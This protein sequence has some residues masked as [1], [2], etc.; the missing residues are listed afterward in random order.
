[1]NALDFWAF[2][3]AHRELLKY[4]CG[5]SFWV[6]ETIVSSSISVIAVLLKL[7]SWAPQWYFS[8]PQP[9]KGPRCSRF[10]L[11]A[12]FFTWTNDWMLLKSSFRF[13]FPRYK[14][15][16]PHRDFLE[17]T[18]AT[19]MLWEVGY[20]ISLLR[21]D[22]GSTMTDDH[23]FNL[24]WYFDCRGQFHHSRIEGHWGSEEDRNTNF[25]GSRS[26]A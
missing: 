18:V 7:Y 5:D 19:R 15:W 8:L 24:L 6:R 11:L 4:V 23:R 25:N 20:F 2:T 13:L 26:W 17:A 1:M 12:R 9:R 21:E 16:T 22:N 10:W 14:G 3:F